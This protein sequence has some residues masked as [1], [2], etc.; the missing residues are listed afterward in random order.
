MIKLGLSPEA[1]IE[2]QH[3][4]Y[5]VRVLRPGRGWATV[6]SQVPGLS[7]ACCHALSLMTD[8]ANRVIELWEEGSQEPAAILEVG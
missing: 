3:K 8:P 2:G 4:S 1:L 6:Y 7:L 5:Q